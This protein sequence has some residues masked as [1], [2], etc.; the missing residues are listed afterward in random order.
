MRLCWRPSNLAPEGVGPRQVQAQGP[1]PELSLP[2]LVA[3]DELVAAT[4]GRRWPVLA[5]NGPVGAGKSTM[6]RAIA[7]LA[8]RRGLRLATASLDDLYV[9][10]AERRSRLAGN[11]FGV[12]RVPP[13]SHDVAMLLERLQAWR[14][15]GILSLPCFDKSLAGGE[16][17]RSGER[18]QEADALLLEGWLMGCRAIGGN[19]L[20]ERLA[21]GLQGW[22][23][24]E[25][26]LDWIPL[27]DR[28][29]ADYGELWRAC[30]GLWLLRPSSWTLPRRWRF[31]AE[32]R[33]RR[34]GAGWLDAASLG[35]LVRSSLNSLP[36][37]LY[38]DPLLEVEQQ[39]LPLL[40]VTVLDGRR[41]LVSLATHSSE[42]SASSA[43]G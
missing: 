26:E 12:S 27:W 34:L 17:D 38:Q 10:L 33:Q 9:P 7:T 15:G 41:R 30:D 21:E 8:R 39:G 28:A 2:V 11:P 6:A 16:G 19:R 20:A 5:L 40:G 32:A 4:A 24:T 25:A 18:Q 3:I 13:G 31:Q 36:P 1:G 37:P 29:L 14:S 35:A 23:L 22:P 42:S 43:I